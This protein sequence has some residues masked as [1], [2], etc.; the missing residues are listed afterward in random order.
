MPA[1]AA[2]LTPVERAEF[3]VE[4]A[5]TELFAVL[6]QA[7][8][9]LSPDQATELTQAASKLVAA[10]QAVVVTRLKTKAY[11]EEEKLRNT[12]PGPDERAA[13]EAWDDAVQVADPSEYNLRWMQTWTR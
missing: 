9:S 11:E 10:A 12:D 1:A 8:V 3:D 4:L 7:G 6:N 2:K 13:A 5:E